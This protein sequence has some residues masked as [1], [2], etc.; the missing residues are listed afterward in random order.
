MNQIINMEM[1]IVVI[2]YRLDHWGS[3]NGM[4][5]L[6]MLYEFHKYYDFIGVKARAFSLTQFEANSLCMAEF[7]T[8]LASIHSSNDFNKFLLL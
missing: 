4:M 1:K 8:T 6:M 3:L 5:V 2:E 7:G